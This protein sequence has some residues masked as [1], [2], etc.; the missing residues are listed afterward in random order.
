MIQL[1]HFVHKLKGCV[2]LRNI[3]Y[4]H[5]AVTY[6]VILT[7]NNYFKAVKAAE[8]ETEV[9]FRKRLCPQL[10]EHTFNSQ[11]TQSLPVHSIIP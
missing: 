5:L 8:E 11:F 7:V 4:W 6:A 10:I 3:P 9:T 1:V 2:K